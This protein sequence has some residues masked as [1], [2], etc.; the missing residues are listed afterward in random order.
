MITKDDIFQYTE[1]GKAVIT[2]YYPQSSSCFLKGGRKNFKIREEE[3]TPSACVFRNKEGIW[4]VQ[5]KGGSDTKARTAIQLV[6]EK[7][8]LTFPQALEW[9]AGKFAPELLER[10]NSY[11]GSAPKP[12]PLIEE[13]DAQESVS[14][15]ER[16][17]GKFTEKELAL[18]GYKITQEVCDEF[19][20][21]PL[22]SYITGRNIKG[23][24]Y[25]CSATPDYPIYY[26][27]YGDWGKIYQPLGEYRFLYVGKKPSNFIFGTREFMST[28]DKVQEDITF[29]MEEK[30]VDED[31]VEINEDRRWPYLFICSGPSD[32]LN[33]YASGLR[34]EKEYQVCWLNSETTKL[35]DYE[36]SCLCKMSKE[37]FLCY[38]IDETGRDNMLKIGLSFLD[39]KL[40][41]LPSDL[42]TFRTAKRSFC[43]DAKDFFMHYR[44]PEIQNPDYLFAD[45][46]K[47]SGSLQ[48]WS[49][50]RDR[51]GK[52]IGYDVNNEQLY[53]FLA[54]S[55]F[56]KIATSTTASGYTFCHIQDNVVELIPADA[57]TAAC[58]DYLLEFLRTHPEYYT[59]ALANTLHRSRQISK[60]SLERLRIVEPNFNSFDH[61]TDCFFFQNGIFKVT[62]A[63]I[64]EVRP[65][66]CPYMV[67]KSKIIP[68]DFHKE[69]P[70]F[71]ITPTKEYATVLNLKAGL[72]PD[73]PKYVAIEKQADEIDDLNRW[74]LEIK[75]KASTF[76]QFV[77]DTGR[78]YWKKEEAGYQLTEEEE[79]ETDL[80]FIAKSLALGYM[81][82]KYKSSGQPYAIYAMEM[83]QSDDGDHLGG[84]GKSLFCNSIENLRQQVYVDG[85]RTDDDKMQFLFQGVVRGV[86]DTI[87][88]DDLNNRLDL[89]R[90]LNM[91]TGKM[92]VDVKHAP[93]FTLDFKESPK[94]C[95]TSN[96]AI[97]NF[98][99]SLNRRIW[100]AA[101]SDYYHSDSIQRGLKLRSP[102]TKFGKNLIEQYTDEEMNHFYNY[103]LTCVQQWHKIGERVNPP[104]KKILAR[105]LQKM[106]GDEF[107][108]WAEDYFIESRLD[109]L[110]DKQEAFEDYKKQLSKTASDLIRMQTFKRKLQDFCIY[111]EWTFN[112]AALLT[113]PSEQKRN[114]IR[115]RID[116]IDRYFFYIDTKN[117]GDDL[118]VESILSGVT[119]KTEQPTEAE[120]PKP[121]F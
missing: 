61:G 89:H 109:C 2:Y 100:F 41:F 24:S 33:I 98:S 112:P 82:S 83:E 87:F 95:F 26:Y 49:E 106:M 54:A 94:L 12:M 5:D 88:M 70:C 48:F 46:L 42:A 113:S 86:T 17:D 7:E 117:C 6:E 4:M 119:E 73:T 56:H 80:N 28:I 66:E 3:R 34:L 10:A 51:K 16:E 104:M 8:R 91:I 13:V 29:K 11:Y 53:N 74:N 62:A 107:L 19:C 78:N 103:M 40:L 121:F 111:K 50:K 99:E 105:T 58:A 47:L 63:G 44:K 30:I 20:L 81:L 77:Y 18:L 120:A 93:S 57:I 114:D 27:D 9:I 79:R 35:S 52:L 116:G 31:G 25:R 84:T 22:K 15:Q 110:I 72:S 68:H 14:V 1:Q 21:K 96:H 36:H 97:R 75:S 65:E 71:N 32:A 23:K 43:K 118:P 102:K 76:M 39:L 55:G 38:D 101:F 115:R 45:L 69:P 59:Q 67:Y 37:R 64:E 90:F 92:V 60:G 108:W 85:Q